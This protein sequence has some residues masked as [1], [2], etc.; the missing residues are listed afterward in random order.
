MKYLLFG[1]GD[2]YN[3]YKKW[4]ESADVVALLDNAVEKQ[5]TVLD[6]IR[7]LSP[8]EGVKLEYDV[9]IILSFY[10]KPMKQQLLELGVEEN[11]IYH[12]YDLHKILDIHRLK[13]PVQ[14]YGD[15]KQIIFAPDITKKKILLLSQD[16]TLGGPAIA[17]YHAAE[18][19]IQHG[20]QVVFG[21]M[22]DGPLKKILLDRG[23]S[24]VVDVNLQLET[25]KENEWINHFSLIFCST[26]NFYVFLSERDCTIPAVWW[27]HDSLFFYDGVDKQCLRQMDKTNLT[28]LSV[29]SV[30][31]QAIHTI[32][33]DLSVN[34]LVYGVEDTA[35]VHKNPIKYDD[36]VCFVTIGY[37]ESR[38][39]QDLL[40]QAILLLPEEIRKKAVFYFV[41]QDSSVMAQQIKHKIQTIP[42]V[43]ITGTV[44][45]RQIDEILN[46]ADVLVCPSRQD[47]M[48]TVA[49]EA[50]MNSVPCLISDA[51]GTA[52]YLT[53]GKNG[54]VFRSEDIKGLSHQLEM[55]IRQPERLGE[56]GKKAR[57]VY[58]K[59]FSM[60][61]FEEALIGTVNDL[62]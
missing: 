53:D 8:Q 57:N 5:N 47:P 50:M 28:V 12:F 54:M 46:K 10:V 7:V 3:R 6:N 32:V 33:P 48:P 52:A 49:A 26:I 41:G 51:T 22:L 55:C 17:L 58:E 20:Y 15:A 44:N 35:D 31:E 61:V 19:L 59:I 23:I 14:Y 62:L 18:I 42:E 34:W 43:I 45:R 40:L 25:M 13:K 38:K 30:P 60:R 29:G 2:Y 36:R 27:L 4:F 11:K 37:I 39:G 56:M 16:M 1:T 24:V 21:S 9:I